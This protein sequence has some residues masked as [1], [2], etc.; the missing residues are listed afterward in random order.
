M[1]I[2]SGFRGARG[3]RTSSLTVAV[4]LDVS[5]GDKALILATSLALVLVT[6]VRAEH[7][8]VVQRAR[9]WVVARGIRP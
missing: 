4:F 9:A 3:R 5:S 7:T 8:V 1:P 6:G 2:L